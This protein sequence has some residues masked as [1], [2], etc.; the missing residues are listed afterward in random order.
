[1][2]ILNTCPL[3][4]IRWSLP[5]WPVTESG[6]S[7]TAISYP[8]GGQGQV[9]GKKNS[10]LQADKDELEKVKKKLEQK[11]KDVTH[12]KS[13]V[14]REVNDVTQER[15][16]LK[17][18]LRL[19]ADAFETLNTAMEKLQADRDK[20]MEVAKKVAKAELMKNYWGR[21]AE[22]YRIGFH[23]GGKEDPC[24]KYFDN[25]KEYD[26]KANT[27]SVLPLFPEILE[28]NAEDKDAVDP[29]GD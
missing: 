21:L 18:D 10:K 12:E 11:V 17:E 19:K 25:P 20:D 22:A 15:N 28:V 16:K 2:M 4:V 7:S 24:D 5:V 27:T 26:S 9:R 13:K 23:D 14:E 3:L 6:I 29:N 1:M 8:I